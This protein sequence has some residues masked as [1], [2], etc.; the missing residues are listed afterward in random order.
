MIDRC[1]YSNQFLQAEPLEST[2]LKIRHSGLVEPQSLGGDLLRP[3][4][5]ISENTLTQPLFERWNRI[6]GSHD[7]IWA[8]GLQLQV[9]S[10]DTRYTFNAMTGV[11]SAPPKVG[12]AGS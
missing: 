2:A 1:E 11:H 9:P 3:L 12:G 7:A 8:R 6:F 4:M 5:D 10:E